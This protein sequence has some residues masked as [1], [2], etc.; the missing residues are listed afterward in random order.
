MFTSLLNIQQTPPTNSRKG[1]QY[2]LNDYLFY[3]NDKEVFIIESLNKI[4]CC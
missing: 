4:I 2:D 1:F 3:P